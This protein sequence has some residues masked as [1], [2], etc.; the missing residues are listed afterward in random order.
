MPKHSI[1]NG[2]NIIRMVETLGKALEYHVET[3]FPLQ[4][5]KV[6]PQAVDVAWFSEE[7]QDFP[8]MIFE[9]E[10]S[11]TNAAANNPV[12]VFGKSNAEFEK[13]L[14]FF[15]I[16]IN[17]GKYSERTNDLLNLFGTYNYRIYQLNNDREVNCLLKDIL[18]QHRRLSNKV[19]LVKF[20]KMLNCIHLKDIDLREIL[21]HIET[22]SF[23]SG[24]GSYLPSYALISQEYPGFRDEFIRYLQQRELS[25]ATESELDNYQTYLGQNWAYPIHLGILCAKNIEDKKRDFYERLK[26]WQEKSSYLT[27]IGPHFG[28]SNDYD[29]FIIGLAGSLWTLVA[30][31]MKEVEGATKFISKQCI[32]ILKA[33]EYAPIQQSFFTA[34]WALHISASS[35]DTQLEFDYVRTYIN[36]RGGVPED[37][38]YEP[39]GGD[40]EMFKESDWLRE[41]NK[42]TFVPEINEFRN[43]VRTKIET[44]VDPISLG[45]NALLEESIWA[46]WG[47][48]LVSVIHK[49]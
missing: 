25:T 5:N 19:N 45:I 4:K 14:F 44:K 7:G 22:N 42:A 46:T 39:L 12:K 6:N 3:E 17:C 1:K 16:F 23:N 8:L 43:T 27:Q 20:I 28:L 24:H 32:D 18:S 38:L 33:L 34:L 10:S 9:I 40:G 2:Q 29:R 21:V 11:A 26:I 35:D 49:W 36:E 41:L 47:K 30:A 15:H 31:L 13:P 48:Q 37:V